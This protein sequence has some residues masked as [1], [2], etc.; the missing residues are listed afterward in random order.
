MSSTSYSLSSETL[1]SS[2]GLLAYL[3]NRSLAAFL[4]LS[5]KKTR[6]ICIDLSKAT[7]YEFPTYLIILYRPAI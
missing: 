2:S 1:I 5:S 6:Y 3:G 4:S 7:S